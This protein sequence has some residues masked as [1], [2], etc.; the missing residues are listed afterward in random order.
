MK[1]QFRTEPLKTR[2]NSVKYDG[3]YLWKQ[4]TGCSFAEEDLEKIWPWLCLEISLSVLSF[5]SSLSD[6]CYHSCWGESILCSERELVYCERKTFI[7]KCSLST[8]RVLQQ[9][10]D[11]GFSQQCYDGNQNN[12][13]VHPPGQANWNPLLFPVWLMHIV[14]SFPLLNAKISFFKWSARGNWIQT[15]RTTTTKTTN[16][17]YSWNPYVS[18]SHLWPF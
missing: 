13:L 7:T 16:Y 10:A 2:E 18:G 1:S 11:L 15:N 3:Y 12:F 17:P 8:Y 5:C 9:C 6:Q 4:T 14:L